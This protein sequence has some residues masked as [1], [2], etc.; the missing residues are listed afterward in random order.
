MVGARGFEPPTSCSQSKHS[1]RLSYA[2]RTHKYSVNSGGAFLWRRYNHTMSSI[3]TPQD[4]LKQ[5]AAQ[6]ALE[7][8]EP[9]EVVGVGSGSTVNFFIDELGARRDRFPVAVSSS[10]ASTE[11]LRSHGIEVLDL[12]QVLASGRRIPVYVD[13]ADEINA[14][15]QMIKGGG[16]ALTRE[17]IVAA[18]SERFVC[19]VDRSKWVER[20]GRFPLPVEVIPMALELV[21][22]RL[23]RLGGVPVA[24]S[25]TITDNGNLVIDVA[26]L[27][28]ENPAALE[29]DINQW[30]GV[31]T[32]GLFARSPA[33][34]ALV[35]TPEGVQVRRATRT[36]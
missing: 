2:P 14:A 17:K 27:S 34:V 24:R 15:L 3:T 30:A 26:G 16:A 21:S 22:M 5:A 1:T 35:A 8:L 29:A 11:R 4:R 18:A 23:R 10:S 31:V 13:G 19:I 33:S 9:G 6:S 7:Y 12:N 20:L 28:I 32:V 36:A 25:G